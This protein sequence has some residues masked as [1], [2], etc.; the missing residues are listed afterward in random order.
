MSKSQPP[1]LHAALDRRTTIFN[2]DDNETVRT[3][4]R[5][6]LLPCHY[7]QTGLAELQFTTSRLQLKRK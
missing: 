4:I 7:R 5:Q 1:G 3:I 6:A 2:T